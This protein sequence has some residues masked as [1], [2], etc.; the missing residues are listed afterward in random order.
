MS[1]TVV[2]AGDSWREI[3]QAYGEHLRDAIQQAVGFY[4]EIAP[5][6]GGSAVEL[7]RRL[8]PYAD[9]ARRQ[10]PIRYAELEG[11]A[12]GAS[13]GLGDA[14][15]LNCVE[16]LTNVEACTTARAAASSFTPRCGTPIRPRLAS[17]PLHPA[18]VRR[19]WRRAA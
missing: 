8:V 1:G 11:M 3:G 15:L 2:H 6:L 7:R 12:E 13:I 19:S 16:D 18:T 5:Q 9:A 10:A 17:S 14:V 4:D